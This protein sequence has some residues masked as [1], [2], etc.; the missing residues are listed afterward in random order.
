VARMEETHERSSVGC[1]SAPALWA[2]SRLEANWI[3]T[4]QGATKESNLSL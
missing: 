3:P 2:S 4:N 1:Y